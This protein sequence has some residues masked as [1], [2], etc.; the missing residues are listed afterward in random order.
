MLTSFGCEQIVQVRATEFDSKSAGPGALQLRSIAGPG[1]RAQPRKGAQY[2]RGNAPGSHNALCLVCWS[3]AYSALASFR[4][5]KK[6]TV[7]T[8][9]RKRATAGSSSGAAGP[10]SAGPSAIHRT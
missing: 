7:N 4:M 6:G 9:R 1:S 10:G 2:R 5:G 8:A 3:F